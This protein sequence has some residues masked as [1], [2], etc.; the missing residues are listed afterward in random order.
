[1]FM[2]LTFALYTSISLI[3]IRKVFF[4]ELFQSR[5]VTSSVES[6]GI[7]NRTIESNRTDGVS[8]RHLY[9]R[10]GAKRAHYNPVHNN[11]NN[12]MDNLLE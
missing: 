7:K 4:N 10:R 8:Y 5:Q 12:T 6:N 9:K 1:M 11:H 3:S 2:S